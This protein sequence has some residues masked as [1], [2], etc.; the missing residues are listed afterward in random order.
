MSAPNAIIAG[1]PF[2][3]VH[4][5]GK[6]EQ[7]EVTDV[8]GQEPQHWV[9]LTNLKSKRPAVVTVWWLRQKGRKGSSHWLFRGGKS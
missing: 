1:Q 3:F 6:R 8:E 2:T 5:S 7:F 4:S 9:R